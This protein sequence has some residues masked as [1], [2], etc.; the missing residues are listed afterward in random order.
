MCLCVCACVHAC[1]RVGG[2]HV[3]SREAL[4]ECPRRVCRSEGS[5]G[6]RGHGG[7][8]PPRALQPDLGPRTPHLPSAPFPSPQWRAGEARVRRPRQARVR[9]LPG[10]PHL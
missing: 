1:V 8:R 2:G 5:G 4:G 9:R 10:W 3:G 7:S 6:V